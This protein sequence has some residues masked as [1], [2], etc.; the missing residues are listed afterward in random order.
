MMEGET[1]RKNASLKQQKL[2]RLRDIRESP[3]WKERHVLA[4]ST[5]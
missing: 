5:G 4:D 2:I 3:V 1:S